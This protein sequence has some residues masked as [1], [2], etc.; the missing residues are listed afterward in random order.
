MEN[1]KNNRKKQSLDND[2]LKMQPQFHIESLTSLPSFTN[3]WICDILKKK[4][5]LN[6]NRRL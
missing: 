4:T 5:E 1:K 6:K 3:G 2:I